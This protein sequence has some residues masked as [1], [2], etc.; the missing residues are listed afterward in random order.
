M[1]GMHAHPHIKTQISSHSHI[2]TP[3]DILPSVRPIIMPAN[4]FTLP[5]EL[6][7]QIYECFLLC[8]IASP[9]EYRLNRHQVRV[10]EKEFVKTVVWKIPEDDPPSTTLLRTCTQI[11][12]EGSEILYRRNVFT[13]RHAIH[14]KSFVSNVPAKYLN[15]IPKVMLNFGVFLHNCS[16]SVPREH[17]AKIGV[18]GGWCD[19]SAN[20]PENMVTGVEQRAEMVAM[21]A[22]IG[23][24]GHISLCFVKVGDKCRGTA[25][26][27]APWDGGAPLDFI[28]AADIIFGGEDYGDTTTKD[29]V[30]AFG[31]RGGVLTFQCL[32]RNEDGTRERMMAF[33]GWELCTGVEPNG[34]RWEPCA[35]LMPDISWFGNRETYE[36]KGVED[37]GVCVTEEPIVE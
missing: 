8:E 31:R 9:Y 10:E 19:K 6:R 16:K 27:I 35:W 12:D 32:P 20:N 24:L 28:I 21:A 18:Y 5:R 36:Y 33:H 23:G 7:D 25:L 34:N 13:F 11:H 1:N 3:S 4:L 17:L 15:M 37:C 30:A 2:L 22:G 29:M 26:L 14:M